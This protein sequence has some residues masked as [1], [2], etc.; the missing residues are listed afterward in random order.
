MKKAGAEWPGKSRSSQV[1]SSSVSLEALPE[2]KGATAL[3]RVAA[4]SSATAKE[5]SLAS[6][7]APASDGAP[8][9]LEQIEAKLRSAIQVSVDE[10]TDLI[11][12]RAQTVQ[13]FILK[14]GQVA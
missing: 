2:V 3:M 10:Q 1:D 11:K 12:R 5:T 14:S 6:Q 4:K 8:L 7:P 13:S 9:T